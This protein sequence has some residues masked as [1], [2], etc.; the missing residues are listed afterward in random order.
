MSRK[1]YESLAKSLLGEKPDKDERPDEYRGWYR[2]VKA[3]ADTLACDNGRFDRGR[4]YAA[5]GVED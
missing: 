5:C 3:V 4:F 2:A 1:D